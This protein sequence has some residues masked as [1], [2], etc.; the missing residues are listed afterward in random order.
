MLDCDAAPV[1]ARRIHAPH[2]VDEARAATDRDHAPTSSS[3]FPG[4]T[5]ADFEA[6]LGLLDEV[7]YDSHL[8]LQIFAAAEHAALALDDQIPEEEKGRRLA[9]VQEQQRAIQIRRNAEL[10]GQRSRSAWWRDSIRRPASGSGG[11]SQNQAR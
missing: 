4:E 10:R 7:E 9:I 8:Q 5:E 1:H 3:D 6:T 2:R 11:T